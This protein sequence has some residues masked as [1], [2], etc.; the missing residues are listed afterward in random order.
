[1]KSWISKY[2]KIS[3]YSLITLLPFIVFYWQIPFLGTK[4]IANDYVAFPIQQQMEMQYGLEKGTFPLFVPD[5][6]GG[7][8]SA[9]LT[10]GQVYHPISHLSA[11]MPGY[12][13]GYALHW[14]TFF[15]LLS[16]GLAHLLLFV[17]LL[18]LK[19]NFIYSFIISFITVYNL[20]ML[21]MFRYGASLENYTAT[22]FL[23]AAM[24]FYYIKPTRF[25]GPA[26]MIFSTYLLV[27]GG[28]PQMMY[29]GL[30]AVGIAALAIPFVLG[31]I[32]GELKPE[33]QRLFRYFR[34][35][36]LTVIVGIILSAAYLLPMAFNFLTTNAQRVGQA[37]QWSLAYS[38][39]TAGLYNSIFAPLQSEVQGAFGGSVLIL[40]AALIPLLYA[41]RVKVPPAIT[42]L[43]G[44]TVVIFLCALGNETPLHY[45][46]WKYLP[47]AG[48]FRVP[49]RITMLLPFLFLLLLAW[50]LARTGKTALVKLTAAATGLY[51]LY[52]HFLVKLLKHP[53]YCLPKH[54]H[55]YP[56]WIEPFV[57]WTGLAVL[58]FLAVDAY[59]YRQN[60][61]E[62]KTTPKK[63]LVHTTTA[64]ILAVLTV[65]QVTAVIRW[66]TWMEPNKLKPPLTLSNMND[67]KKK[68]LRYRGDPGYGMETQQVLIQKQRSILEPFLAKFY[69]NYRW[70][71]DQR[72]AYG[73]LARENATRTVV[74]EADGA[75]LEAQKKDIGITS[76]LTSITAGA[77]E[78]PYTREVLKE[79]DSVKLEYASYNRLVFSVDAGA[80]GIL[81]QSYPYGVGWKARVN[82]KPAPIV[83]ANGYMQGIPLNAGRHTVEF[84]IESRW[85]VTGMVISCLMLMLTA[86]YFAYRIPKQRRWRR[87]TGITASVLVPAVLFWTFHA[88]LYS[89]EDLKTEYRWTSHDFPP[90]NNLAYAK[91]T[92]MSFGRMLYYSGFGVDGY[93]ARPFITDPIKEKGWWQVDL[94]KPKPIGEI[95]VYL[96]ASELTPHLPLKIL[97]SLDGKTF[98]RLKTV[99]LAGPGQ[100][101]R[102][103]MKGETAR[104][105]R[106]ESAAMET[107]FSLKEV[108]VYPYLYRIAGSGNT[109]LQDTDATE[110]IVWNKNR[111][112]SGSI[113]PALTPFGR[114]G[115]Y[116]I[117]VLNIDNSNVIRVRVTEPGKKGQRLL[118]LGYENNRNG[119]VIEA[120]EGKTVHFTVTAAISPNL[121]NRK[122]YLL[123]VD[124]DGHGESS[125][126]IYFTGPN[127]KIYTASKKVRP[128]IKRLILFIRFQPETPDDEL[129]IRNIKIHLS[130]P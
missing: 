22:L 89:G 93:A 119:L 24:A 126:K 92:A 83:R 96:A 87:I 69:R 38:S 74:V 51:L 40:M 34:T 104:Q 110:I 23:C 42:I 117:D 6:A 66:G 43:W 59:L 18:R 84:K 81:T 11:H 63:R 10:L 36:V 48:N 4:T 35:V 16:L 127:W 77:G 102:I 130:N 44:G 52:N 1:M 65:I 85:G 54:I 26:A 45:Y 3:L 39:T 114:K 20:R 27:C 21:D 75:A 31:A 111:C 94:G 105:I 14:N 106:L 8:T 103:K 70:V 79:T 121:V 78:K 61:N 125:P 124:N 46:F 19:L 15:R 129:L 53:V 123:I 107:S 108:E 113:S 68:N 82:G 47:M 97:G 13:D 55:Q 30:L 29:L 17:L 76:N 88:G 72:R 37:Y 58:I 9:A 122:N 62:I 112:K 25:A 116:R 41:F 109:P 128:G 67:Q 80:P 98:K 5:F 115:K 33:R 50:L 118:N 12:W 56:Q 101:L 28:H 99:S 100:P 32:S 95:V 71:P 90:D 7:Q 60:L 73:F 91:K 86:G 64:A 120:P 2:S 49:G 57:Q